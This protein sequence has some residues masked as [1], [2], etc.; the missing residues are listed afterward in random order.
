MTLIYSRYKSL[1]NHTHTHTF[2][3]F[4]YCCFIYCCKWK[5]I[6][7]K[8]Y[9]FVLYAK[10]INEAF[11]AQTL[12]CA[13]SLGLDHN[14]LNVNGGAIALGHPLGKLNSPSP[15]TFSIHYNP[16]LLF[17]QIVIRSNVD[18]P[19]Y[20]QTVSQ[21]CLSKIDLIFFPC[22]H[23][24]TH[25]QQ[26]QADHVLQAIWYMSLGNNQKHPQQLIFTIFNFI[27]FVCDVYECPCIGSILRIR[28]LSESS[29]LRIVV[30]TL[31]HTHTHIY[32]AF[33]TTEQ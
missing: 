13:D 4:P 25:E 21:N 15:Y 3:H 7:F 32:I 18:W 5:L 29:L 28:L 16:V 20:S 27:S 31:T 14:K 12:A 8:V 11:S 6:T 17:V 24:H 9:I 1:N 2:M 10:Q 19:D 26:H 30:Y 33:K 23:T 22:L